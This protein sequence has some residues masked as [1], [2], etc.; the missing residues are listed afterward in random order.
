MPRKLILNKFNS[1]LKQWWNFSSI[2]FENNV[3]KR[4]IFYDW[5]IGEVNLL[6][7]YF[8]NLFENKDRTLNTS[9]NYTLPTSQLMDNYIFIAPNELIINQ[10][11]IKK[12]NL[13]F[14]YH[15]IKLLSLLNIIVDVEKLN[16]VNCTSV[17]LE[18]ELF[19]F[20]N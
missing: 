3:F 14:N 10:R 4:Y 16:N 7:S 20:K 13:H 8:F 1:N 18:A 19:P 2:L 12:Y 17:R 11:V 15:M 6:E 9:N 5:I